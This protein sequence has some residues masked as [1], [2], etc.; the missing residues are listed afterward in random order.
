MSKILFGTWTKT[1]RGIMK[2]E[3]NSPL[4]SSASPMPWLDPVVETDK[5]CWTVYCCL[6]RGDQ[7]SSGID[8]LKGNFVPSFAEG[9]TAA[10]SLV[11]PK[12]L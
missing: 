3:L 12:N 7:P 9:V 8:S 4:I 6:Y 1:C 5:F 11:Y 2:P 10:K